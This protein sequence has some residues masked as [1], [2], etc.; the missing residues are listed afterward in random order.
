MILGDLAHGCA[1]LAANSLGSVR[2][3]ATLDAT[4]ATAGDAAAPI[5]A[6]VCRRQPLCL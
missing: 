6:A 3:F 2:G 1:A 4:T 5:A